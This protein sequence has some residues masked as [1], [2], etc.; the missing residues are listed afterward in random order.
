MSDEP[1][2]SWW[3]ADHPLR[4]IERKLDE[5]RAWL[6]E[7]F[8]NTERLIK[9]SQTN[10]QSIDAA[11]TALQSGLDRVQAD[12]TAIAAELSANI[13]TPG[14]VPTAASV[15]ALQT[16]VTRLQ[17]VATSLDALVVPAVVVTPP[18]PV[19]PGPVTS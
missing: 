19:P 9:M 7:I 1:D 5:N 13:P 10:Q 17:T 15:A 3:H 12:V 8:S 11:N 2:N 14:A 16:Q 6:D 4:R 18:A